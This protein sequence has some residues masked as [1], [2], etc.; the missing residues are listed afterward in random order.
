MFRCETA[1]R[2]PPW[3][4][5]FLRGFSSRYAFTACAKVST[6]SPKFMIRRI[7]DSREKET[8]SFDTRVT[9]R[10]LQNTYGCTSNSEKK[11]GTLQWWVGGRSSHVVHLHLASLGEVIDLFS[12]ARSRT[13]EVSNAEISLARASRRVGGETG[14]KTTSELSSSRSIQTPNISHRTWFA[15]NSRN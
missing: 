4:W 5:I 1:D 11:H 12:S 8:E 13:C 7:L 6:A 10:S 14:T 15:R 3:N 9:S 2:A